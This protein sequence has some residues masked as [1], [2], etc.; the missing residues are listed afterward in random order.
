MTDIPSDVSAAA[1][2]S[3]S[4]SLVPSPQASL[5]RPPGDRIGEKISHEMDDPNV[6]A[7]EKEIDQLV[8]ELYG[9]TPQEI[10][11]VEGKK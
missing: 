9:L 3:V 8:Y 10:E 6:T 4:P 1:S 2:A 5:P 7:H 11:R